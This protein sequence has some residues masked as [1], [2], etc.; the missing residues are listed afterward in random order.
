MKESV[1]N[2]YQNELTRE[3]KL[4]GKQMPQ[5]VG[6]RVFSDKKRN[7]SL[8]LVTEKKQIYLFFAPW[9]AHCFELIKTL[10]ERS[11]AEFW[12]KTSMVASG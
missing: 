11:T 12:E 10:S 3:F 8:P 1:F 9:C 5:V 2:Q 4:T 7:V 6:E